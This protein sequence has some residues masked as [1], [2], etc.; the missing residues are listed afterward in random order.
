MT[1]NIEVKPKPYTKEEYLEITRRQK[2]LEGYVSYS[3]TR[4]HQWIES[5]CFFLRRIFGARD[6]R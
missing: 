4:N 2:P 5:F 3:E 6:P 1:T